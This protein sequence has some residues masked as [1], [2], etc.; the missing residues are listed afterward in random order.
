MLMICASDVKTGGPVLAAEG[1]VGPVAGV[2]SRDGSPELAREPSPNMAFLIYPL[3][4][5]KTE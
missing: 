4:V 5:R 3:T 1:L 2:P